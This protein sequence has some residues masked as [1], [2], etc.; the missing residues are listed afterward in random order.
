MN[1]QPNTSK[2]TFRLLLNKV[3]LSTHEID[4]KNVGSCYWIRKLIVEY[5][6]GRCLREEDVS[7]V[8]SNDADNCQIVDLELTDTKG[9]AGFMLVHPS[10]QNSCTL[11]GATEIYIPSCLNDRTIKWVAT[12]S[13]ADVFV[14]A[15]NFRRFVEEVEDAFNPEIKQEE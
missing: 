12:E 3:V 9:A 4:I 10:E 8:C 7:V 2:V 15:E 11:F 5:S 1:E 6:Q 13:L 14:Y